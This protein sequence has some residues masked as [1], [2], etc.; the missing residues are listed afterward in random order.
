MG[1]AEPPSTRA[2]TAARPTDTHLCFMRQVCTHHCCALAWCWELGPCPASVLPLN[3]H[4]AHVEGTGAVCG[5][6]HLP[7]PGAQKLLEAER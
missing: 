4:V 3:V 6:K 5:G 7:E 2:S 1:R